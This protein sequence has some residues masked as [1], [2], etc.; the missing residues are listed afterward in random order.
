MISDEFYV[1]GVKNG[2]RT[3]YKKF[4]SPKLYVKSNKPSEF[5][6]LE[7]EY[8]KEIQPGTV[9]DCREFIKKYEEIENFK[10]YGNERFLYQFIS[11][12]YPSDIEY[13][14]KDIKIY[15]LDIE[16]TTEYGFPN[17]DE[18]RE[19]ILLISIQDFNSKKITTFGTRPYE[20]TLNNELREKYIENGVNYIEC[21]SEKNLLERFVEFLQADFP[22]ILTGHNIKFFDIPYI[23]GRLDRV[24]GDINC[25]SPWEYV[26][27]RE[28]IVFN[29]KQP[30]YYIQGIST[31]DYLE[32]YKKFRLI[33]REN[34]KLNYLCE[35]ELG[36]EKLDHSEFNSF[37]DFYTQ[38]WNKFVDY[39]IIDTVL[40]NKLEEKLKLIA[41]AINMAY[42]AKVNYSDVLYQ[43]RTWDMI[44]FNYLKQ[45]GIIIPPKHHIEKSAKFL[46]A[47]VKEP[48]PGAYDWVVNTDLNSLYPNLIC[49]FNI[50]PETLINKQTI[51][52]RI[53]QLKNYE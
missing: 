34:Y 48:N 31:L 12:E 18:C 43:V 47:Y 36:Q 33:P 28:E 1:R 23:C 26:Y 38:N 19:E 4:Y 52:D 14:L 51:I 35:C 13:N 16:T 17:L 27:P 10:I 11:D 30:F 29:R 49:Q 45:F 15:S 6:T 8:L 50:S 42:D 44:I 24:I 46:G 3:E 2:R 20:C 21:F 53:H 5:R 41:L 32:L 7:G 40:V 37:K 39:N 22:D 25:L 9:K